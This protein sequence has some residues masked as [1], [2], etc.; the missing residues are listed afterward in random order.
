MVFDVLI[1]HS[2]QDRAFAAKLTNALKEHGIDVWV[3]L[4][5]LIEGKTPIETII[6]GISRCRTVLALF[7]KATE[8]E[9]WVRGEM[10]AWRVDNYKNRPIIIPVKIEEC[11]LPP[12]FQL[13]A[14]IDF[15]HG[16]FEDNVDRMVL[17]LKRIINNRLVFICHSSRDKK[18]VNR[19]A[20]WLKRKRSIDLWYDTDAL[21][22]GSILRRKIESGIKASDYLVAILSKRAIDTINGWI[23]FELDQA[24]EIERERNQVD[25]YFVVPVVIE[26]RIEIPGWLSTKVY[27][28]LTKDFD[29]GMKL[30][31]KSISIKPP[32]PNVRISK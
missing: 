29:E 17:G 6:E 28:D 23:G 2:G 4:E 11:T 26:E 10:D 1:S 22:A 7:S 9:M 31:F 20:K 27:V 15:T 32:L 16:N 18:Q 24:Y 30:L 3:A 5:P 13:I 14:G 8:S 19:I 21:T 12:E 25:H